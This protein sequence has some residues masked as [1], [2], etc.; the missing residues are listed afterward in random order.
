[1]SIKFFLTLIF[2]SLLGVGIV[3]VSQSLHAQPQRPFQVY[4]SGGYCVFV[5]GYGATASIA[6]QP[7]NLN[8]HAGGCSE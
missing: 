1:M 6:V 8:F 5:S 2:I 4:R 3:W 7:L